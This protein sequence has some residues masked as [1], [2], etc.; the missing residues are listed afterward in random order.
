[1]Y[2]FRENTSLGRLK[3]DRVA[4]MDCTFS[5]RIQYEYKTKFVKNKKGYKCNDLLVAYG[6]G[7]LPAR[8]RT[9]K[10]WAI[11]VDK[12]YTP[13]NVNGDHWISLCVDFIQRT[14][15]VFDCSG[16]KRNSK[17]VEPFRNLIPRIV[18]EVQPPSIA[19]NLS[20][21]PYDV[22]Y[23]PMQDGLNR[24]ACNCGPYAMKF[25]ELHML[26]L[27]LS[28]VN[29]ECIA[30]VRHKFAVEL[31]VA[32]NDPVFIERMSK[33]VPTTFDSEFDTVDIM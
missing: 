30:W 15:Q 19:K 17:H 14:I 18:K 1:M 23:V 21:T 33:Y 26:G 28:L 2:L 13:V 12:L 3:V 29:D 16:G 9:S 7:E 27:D 25:I 32:A 8:G 10:R 22:T 31:W 11:D 5:M 6:N 4:F 24:S 20:I